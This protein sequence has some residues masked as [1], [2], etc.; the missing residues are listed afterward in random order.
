MKKNK[1]KKFRLRHLLLLLFS[2]YVATTFISQQKTLRELKA[3]KRMKEEEIV[4]LEKEVEQLNDEINHSDSL[5]F[6]EKV[7]REELNMV[8]PNEVI[9]VDKNKNKNSFFKIRKP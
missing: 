6:V 7:A 2:L 8:K 4:E 5:E 9:Y 1:K 3:Q